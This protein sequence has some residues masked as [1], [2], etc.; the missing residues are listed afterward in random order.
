MNEGS[1]CCVDR[2]GTD[3][4]SLFYS[5]MAKPMRTSFTG[6]VRN[7]DVPLRIHGESSAMLTGCVMYIILSIVAAVWK[8][9]MMTSNV[10]LFFPIYLFYKELYICSRGLAH[11]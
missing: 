7:L 3:E 4:T 1:E 11:S 6:N 2:D 5:V 8:S 10:M 9:Y